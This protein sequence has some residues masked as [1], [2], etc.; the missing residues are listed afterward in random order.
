MRDLLKRLERI[1]GQRHPEAARHAR[2]AELTRDRLR[3][4][5]IEPDPYDEGA[6][7]I[8]DSIMEAIRE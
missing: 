3:D 8:V 2:I 5:G 7:L 1:E 4:Q 6:R